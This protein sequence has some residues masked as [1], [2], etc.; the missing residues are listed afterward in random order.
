MAS[1]SRS[2]GENPSV[3]SAP[4]ARAFFPARARAVLERL[5]FQALYDTP[6]RL[7]ADGALGASGA[8]ILLLKQS[9]WLL[10]FYALTRVFFAAA[11][12]RL[13]GAVSFALSYLIWHRGTRKWSGTG[14]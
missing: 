8:A 5:P 14:T 9:L 13:V 4:T 7:L 12:K 3:S 2:S 11:L 1:P 10:V 6:V